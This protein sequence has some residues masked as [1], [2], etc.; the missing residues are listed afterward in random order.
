MSWP[1]KKSSPENRPMFIV[2][3]I[4]A[5]EVALLDQTVGEPI[6]PERFEA[7]LQWLESG[8]PEKD[9][10]CPE[11]LPRGVGGHQP[12]AGLPGSRRRGPSSAQTLRRTIA[13]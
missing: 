6:S 11:L 8:R 12:A 10:P 5:D 7:Y 1:E 9:N 13:T 4:S 3:G 2:R